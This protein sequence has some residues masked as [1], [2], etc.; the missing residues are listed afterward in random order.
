MTYKLDTWCNRRL[1]SK[2]HDLCRLLLPGVVV[3][4][5]IVVAVVLIVGCCSYFSSNSSSRSTSAAGG[6]VIVEQCCCCS[7]SCQKHKNC[8]CWY[9]LVIIRPRSNNRDP[10]LR[11]YHVLLSCHE[12][13]FL[14]CHVQHKRPKSL[15][16]LHSV[17]TRVNH[18]GIV[19]WP[20]CQETNR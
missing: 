2:M 13:F 4:V 3:A 9:T 12:I 14:H 8:F 15:R 6:V 11:H 19:S 5:V 20:S 18:T 7:F 10:L 16:H 1:L 17:F